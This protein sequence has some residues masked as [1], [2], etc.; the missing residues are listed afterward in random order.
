VLAGCGGAPA[1]P[2]VPRPAAPQPLLWKVQRPGGPVTW[3]YGTIHNAGT[4]HVP[5][6]AWQ[7]LETAPRF[8]SELGDTEPDPEQLVELV[9]LP[10]GPGLDG[11]LSPDDWY[12]LRDALRGV[13][14]EP[15]LARVR[16]WFA[17]ARLTAT[18][19]PSPSPTMDF[20]LAKHARERGIPVEPLE[21]WQDQLVALADGVTLADLQQAI[22]ER[23]QVRCR[24]E[25]LRAIYAAGDLDAIAGRILIT[26]MEN[27]I[28]DRT[29]AWLPKLEP[30][31]AGGGFVA[32]GIGHL[33]GDRGLVALLERAGYQVE[34]AP[35]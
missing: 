7:A 8:V 33:I 20:A 29:E 2:V 31:L 15:E 22:R 32:V 1:C 24:L 21:S 19:A 16:P 9:R 6:A 5:R 4:E 17:M 11:Q 12:D 26:T 18:L 35:P 3:L 27:L 30:V 25:S 34:R 14:R 10:R 13:I 23:K 28:V